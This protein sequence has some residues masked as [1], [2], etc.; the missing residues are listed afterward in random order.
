MGAHTSRHLERCKNHCGRERR[1]CSK[2]SGEKRRKCEKYFVEGEQIFPGERTYRPGQRISVFG[3]VIIGPGIVGVGNGGFRLNEAGLYVISYSL[4]CRGRGAVSM[5]LNNSNIEINGSR[6]SS[7]NFRT[8]N[9]LSRQNIIFNSSEDNQIISLVARN[10]P[11]GNPNLIVS[12]LGVPIIE[13]YR[14]SS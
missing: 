8:I 5:G 11:S 14:V 9:R 2:H 10:A 6:S 13:I 3:G 1:G 7:N 12:P 4:R